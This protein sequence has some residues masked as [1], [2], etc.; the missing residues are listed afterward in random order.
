MRISLLRAPANTTTHVRRRQHAHLNVRLF[1][2]IPITAALFLAFAIGNSIARSQ[3]PA[4]A[5]SASV[6][7]GM[8]DPALL[9]ETPNIQKTQLARMKRLGITSVRFD[10]NWASVQPASPEASNW[11]PLD[12]AVDSTRSAG[13][14]VDLIIDG[15]PPWAAVPGAGENSFAQPASPTM[16]ATWAAQVVERFAPRGVKTYEIWNEPNIAQF[17]WPSPNP[18][19]YTADLKAAYSAIKAVDPS[20]FVISGGLSPLIPGQSNYSPVAFLQAMYANGAKGYFDALGYHPYSFPALPD[21]RGSASGWSQMAHADPSLRGVMTSNGDADKPIWITEFGAPSGGPTGVGQIKQATELRQ[22]IQ[23]AKTVPWIGA[24]YIYT[25]QDSASIPATQDWFGLLSA[26][27][28]P[29]L[30]YEQ[31]A[32]AIR[33]R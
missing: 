12:Q 5:G 16:Y 33:S 32:N 24:L 9:A 18:I 20:A 17:W 2:A 14:S 13:M 4:A 21:T 29:K 11:G 1:V 8:S 26:Q 31:V 15:C 7:F 22:A 25:W 10:A 3:S 6:T 30:A 19:A 23:N 27:G 28:T